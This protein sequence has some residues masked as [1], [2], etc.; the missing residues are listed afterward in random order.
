MRDVMHSW[1]ALCRCFAT[2][3]NVHNVGKRHCNLLKYFNI[4]KKLPDILKYKIIAFLYI[5]VCDFLSLCKQIHIYSLRQCHY[6]LYVY[7]PL[8][9]T[10]SICHYSPNTRSYEKFESTFKNYHLCLNCAFDILSTSN[11][12]NQKRLIL[13][14]NM[15]EECTLQVYESVNEYYHFERIENMI[16][17]LKVFHNRNRLDFLM[18]DLN[19]LS[20]FWSVQDYLTYI[21]I[22]STKLIHVIDLFNIQNQ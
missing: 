20:S 6:E 10:C 14:N 16:Q 4:F 2:N 17:Q 9:H 18:F 1:C 12:L 7:I 21:H 15:I 5:D 8:H 3:V 19:L 22:T 13:K 11:F